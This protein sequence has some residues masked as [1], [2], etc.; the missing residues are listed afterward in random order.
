MAT[1]EEFAQ[2]APEIAA[3]GHRILAKYGIAYLGTV[4]GDGGPRITP[5]SPVVVDGRLYLG[6]MPG[7]P[8]RAD[9]D[10]DS[11]CVIHTLPGP[12]DAEVSLRGRANRIST[13]TLETLIAQAPANVRFARDT[14][15]Y[16]VQLDQVNCTTF[17]D[18]ADHPRPLPTRTRWPDA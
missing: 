4:R 18:V 17:A 6:I 16:E 14:I 5:I 1:W 12:G 3:L 11:R 13:G 15:I 7:T 9:L 2:E 10:R 8:K